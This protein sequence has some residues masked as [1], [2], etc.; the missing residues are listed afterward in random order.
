MMAAEYPTPATG[1][2]DVYVISHNATFLLFNLVGQVKWLVF[3]VV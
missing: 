1:T 2:R 3:W